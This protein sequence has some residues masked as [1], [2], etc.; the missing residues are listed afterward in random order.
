MELLG[1][2]SPTRRLDPLVLGAP[3]LDHHGLDLTAARRVRYVL[4]QSFRYEYD[5]P[6]SALRQ[7]LVIVP[8][9]RHGCQ[10]LRA[11]RLEVTGAKASR[12]VQRD[13]DGNVVAVLRAE[14]VAQAIEFRLAAVIE[15]VHDDGPLLLPASALHSSRLLRPTPLTTADERLREMAAGLAVRAR[16]AGAEET[17]ALVND[18]VADTLSYGNG[19]TSVSTTAAEAAAIGHGV[20][21][22]YA[23][24]MLAICHELG[25]PA[26]Y[27]S[28]HL[29]G[30]GGTH[31]WVEVI[32]ARGEAA[33]AVAFDP[34]NR[35]RAGA[36]YLTVATGR[37]Y[38]DVAPT[39]GS[40][41][42]K[43]SGRLTAQRRV[44][45]VAAALPLAGTSEIAGRPA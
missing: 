33:E 8:P 27:V 1:T 23:H 5:A 30:Q 3:L 31:A 22:D 24:I 41:E 34:C 17:A 38:G 19:F 2:P 14:R 9:P 44:G 20:C 42:G 28:G 35:R 29:L 4:E 12:R 6:V 37:D 15:R 36:G 13:V 7:R 18:A 11:H 39:S 26:R 32:V 16:G 21:Q 25:L 45:V 10:Y 43:G 40:Y